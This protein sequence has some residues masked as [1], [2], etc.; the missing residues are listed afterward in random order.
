MQRACSTFPSGAGSTDPEK[1]RQALGPYFSMEDEPR[2]GWLPAS[3]PWPVKDLP[4]WTEA[5]IDDP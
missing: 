4:R 3:Q 5:A 1:V 2:P